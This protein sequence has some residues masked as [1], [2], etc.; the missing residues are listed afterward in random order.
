MC[1]N[2][3]TIPTKAAAWATARA[4]VT[5]TDGVRRL[6]KALLPIDYHERGDERDRHRERDDA[7][8]GGGVEGWSREE[9]LHHADF[10]FRRV[11]DK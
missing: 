9:R 6:R 8:L 4:R 3:A 11:C 10:R 2:P 5:V 7:D 1:Q